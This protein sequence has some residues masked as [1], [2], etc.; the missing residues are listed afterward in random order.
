MIP[1]LIGILTILVTI[2]VQDVKQRSIWWFLPP[3]LFVFALVY[4]WDE[5]NILQVGL[6]L[7]FITMLLVMLTAYVYFRFHS[8]SLF[9]DYFGLGDALLLIAITPFFELNVF[10][11]FFTAA[12]LG[13]LIIY[14]I[15]SLFKKQTTIPYAGY[16]SCFL[17]V[18]LSSEV[19]GW[20][21]TFNV[22]LL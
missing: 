14:G 6:N 18:L 17:I 4:R 1:L 5:L 15:S 13:S 8:L 21:E 11:Y 3:L 22:V 19:F 10:I 2:F 20:L 16:V 12:T 9:K 7:L